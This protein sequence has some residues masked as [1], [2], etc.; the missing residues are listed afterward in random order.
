MGL[1]LSPFSIAILLSYEIKLFTSTALD[2]R[3]EGIR[4]RDHL[5]L[6]APKPSANGKSL[7]A[8]L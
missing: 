4:Y 2:A 3:N 5:T 1:K 6:E 8:P 7:Q